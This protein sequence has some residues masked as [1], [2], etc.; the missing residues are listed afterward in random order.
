MILYLTNVTSFHNTAKLFHTL[1][2]FYLIYGT[3]TSE[4][5]LLFSYLKLYTSQMQMCTM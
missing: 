3:F 5:R 4:M 2:M 1:E